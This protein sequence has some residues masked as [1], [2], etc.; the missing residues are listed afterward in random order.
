MRRILRRLSVGVVVGLIV[1]DSATAQVGS[2]A[3]ISGTVRDETGAVLPGADVTATQIDTG[4]T[5]TVLADDTGSY[6]LPN[7]PIRPYRLQVAHLRFRPYVQTGIVLQV[8]ANAIINVTLLVGDLTETIAVKGG[9]SL[10]ETRSPSI[11]QVIENERIE[12]LP[13][14]GRQATDL[15]VLAGAAVRPGGVSDASS[16]SMQAGLASPS[17]ADRPSVSPTC[18]TVRCTTTRMTI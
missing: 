15:I 10:V 6:I 4:A 3:Q 18:S 8:N 2:S 14:N 17:R 1:A 16:R 9:A 13:L 11:G 7:L 12:E 5:R